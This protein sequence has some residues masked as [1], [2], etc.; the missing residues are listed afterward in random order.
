MKNTNG[1]FNTETLLKEALKADIIGFDIIQ[2]HYEMKERKRFL[3]KHQAKIWQGEDGGFFTYLPDETAKQKRKLVRKS[4]MEK[5]E[6]AIVDF[7]KSL[8][9]APTINKIFEAWSREK[10]EIGEISK[11]TFDRYENDFKRFIINS[12]LDQRNI[13][14]ITDEMLE[15]FIR[16]AIVKH[17]LS[18][19]AFSNLRTLIIGT[20][21]YAKRKK[22][23]TL[24][25]STFFK[26]VQLSRKAFTK[27]YKTKESQVFNEDE[28]PILLSWL[29]ENPSIEN[30]GII[31]CFQSGIREGEL[32]AVKFLDV[33]GKMLHIQRQEIKYKDDITKKCTHEIVEY[34]KTDAGNRYII[35][36]EKALETIAKIR[37]LNPDGEYLMQ[38]GNRHFWTNTF[39]DR[40]YKACDAC[41][42]PR[43]SMHKIRKTY[44]TT[45][46]D[47][48]VDDSLIMSQMGHS[49][50]ATTR[51]YYY[52]SNKNSKQNEKQID[53]AISF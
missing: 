2:M 42:I 53:K 11:G 8:E 6:D 34:T 40:L 41:G 39:N 35:L 26:D 30:Y 4:T 22:L 21:Q 36:T 51:K 50:I 43:R 45:L 31:L 19:K 5:L 23:T 28:I 13:R 1:K 44:G 25:I 3:E 32:S 46:I 18:L 38:R 52:F 12:S 15:E 37:E 27:K 48:N 10:L 29:R 17:K 49:D 14:Y 9:E 24:S 33:K 47:A 16:K 7:Y 20:F